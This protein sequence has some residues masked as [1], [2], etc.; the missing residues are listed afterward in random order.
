MADSVESLAATVSDLKAR[1]D[2]LEERVRSLENKMWSVAGGS[3]VLAALVVGYF[4]VQLGSV[5]KLVVQQVDAKFA[6]VAGIEA[7][8][9]LKELNAEFIALGTAQAV[10]A[11]YLEAQMAKTFAKINTPYR[12]QWQP[13]PIWMLSVTKDGAVSG[14]INSPVTLNN[15]KQSWILTP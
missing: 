14:D 9:H 13:N 2:R 8:R 11:N 12:I 3:A 10:A 15:A 6:D 7:T 5:P 1:T 4:G